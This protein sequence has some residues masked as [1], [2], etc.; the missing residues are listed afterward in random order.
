MGINLISPL[1]MSR[2]RAKYVVVATNCFTKWVEEELLATITIKKVMDFVVR[3]IIIR[4]DNPHW[5]FFDNETK[6]ESENIA[7]LCHRNWIIK[8]F[9]SVADP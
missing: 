5:I 6:F 7:R 4:F 8:Q 1:Q 2:G 9:S 3:N